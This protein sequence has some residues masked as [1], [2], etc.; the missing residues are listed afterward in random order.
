MCV[1]VVTS[2]LC[3][4]PQEKWT[5]GL[6]HCRPQKNRYS[7]RSLLNHWISDFAYN[8]IMISRPNKNT[9]VNRISTGGQSLHNRAA[10][11]AVN[12]LSTCYQLPEHLLYKPLT[13]TY[14]ELLIIIIEARTGRSPWGQSRGGSCDCLGSVLWSDWV[15]ASANHIIWWR[16]CVQFDNVHTYDL[17][18]CDF[19]W[20]LIYWTTPYS[21]LLL[22][23]FLEI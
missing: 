12:H 8:R 3:I 14:L 15:K 17:F 13:Y 1:Y 4:F 5:T 19:H 18:C 9:R 21:D 20:S 11:G 10:L 7:V 16:I 2:T 22:S 6:W 23:C